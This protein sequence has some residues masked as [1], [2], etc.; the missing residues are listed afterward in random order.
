MKLKK[1]ASLCSENKMFILFDR[2]DKN[3]EVTQW[4][5][6]GVGFYPILG[7]PILDTDNICTMF[8]VPAKKQEKCTFRQQEMPENINVADD[9]VSD[10]QLESYGFRVSLDGKEIIPLKGRDGLIC[11]QSKY[12]APLSDVA[13][14]T[15]LY[16]RTMPSGRPAI[17][18]KAGL[19]ISAVICP[20]DVINADFVTQLERLSYQCNWE[21]ARKE[22]AERDGEQDSLFERES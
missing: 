9:D 3:G 12:L 15:C 14:M 13:D 17:V 8:E 16:E 20:V 2:V 4:L 21:L 22:Q 5:G 10:W 6:D 18:V 7:L 19:L 11:V 1:V